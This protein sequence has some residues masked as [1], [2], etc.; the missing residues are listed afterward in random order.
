[1]DQAELSPDGTVDGVVRLEHP[2]DVALGVEGPSLEVCMAR[3]AAG[4]FGVMFRPLPPPASRGPD[5]VE[6]QLESQSQAG[7]ARDWLEELLRRSELENL[8]FYRFGL[9]IAMD[10]LLD[11]KVVGLPRQMAAHLRG[12]SI[13]GVSWPDL[14]LR[15]EHGQ[16]W[17]H[18]VLNVCE[19]PG[20][21]NGR[22]SSVPP[23]NRVDEVEPAKQL[24]RS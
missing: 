18:V 23:D 15:Y 9:E 13:K 12:P 21:Q 14:G 4:M 5:T 19:T 22:G 20:G 8:L 17:L 2:T 3:A 10:R 16:W 11:G 6:L 24:M 7:L 1:M